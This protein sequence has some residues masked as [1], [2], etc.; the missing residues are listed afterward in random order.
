[1]RKENIAIIV[2]GDARELVIVNNLNSVFFNNNQQ[3]KVIQFPAGQN[4]YI[5][6]KQLKE[7]DFDTDIIE[8]VRE[9]DDNAK[10]ILEGLSRDDFSEVYLFFDYDAHQNNLGNGIES[11]SILEQMLSR[12]DN[13]TDNGKLYI[14]YP[15]VEALRDYVPGDCSGLSKCYCDLNDIS[16]YKNSS[17]K[18]AQTSSFKNYSIEDWK[19][20]INVFVLRI[21][22]LLDRKTIMDY[23]EYSLVIT[24]KEI[25]DRENA[26]VEEKK[27]LF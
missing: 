2:E 18:N 8:I 26:L 1:M 16:K 13:E 23:E 21:C 6:W 24:P 22:C 5:L 3:I 19:E 20:L 11:G 27:F 14:S 10:E 4:I 12:F 17:A 7:D 25:F 15:M 9:Y